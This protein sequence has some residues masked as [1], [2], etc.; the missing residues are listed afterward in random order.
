MVYGPE[1]GPDLRGAERAWHVSA[2]TK[3]VARS[4]SRIPLQHRCF[5]DL[6]AVADPIRQHAID[7]QPYGLSEE[8]G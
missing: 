4:R 5:A 6:P 1:L 2:D 8:T 3:S 7:T